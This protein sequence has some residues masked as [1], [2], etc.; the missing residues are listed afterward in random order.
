[1]VAEES[2][3]SI[4]E[5]D[6][7]S[8]NGGQDS[9]YGMESPMA[10]N[11]AMGQDFDLDLSEATMENGSV[12]AALAEESYGNVG[13]SEMGSDSL[14][15]ATGIFT[16][17]GPNDFELDLS[18]A[19]SENVMPSSM[20]LD[21]E[22]EEMEISDVEIGESEDT[23]NMALFDSGAE[24]E[25]EAEIDLSE[26]ALDSE[27]VEGMG[28]GSDSVDEVNV[29]VADGD[30]LD[31]D[32]NIDP[33]TEDSGDLNL[34][35]EEVSLDE[36]TDL[37]LSSDDD[38]MAEITSEE[39]TEGGIEFDLDMGEDTD[40]P[41][42]VDDEDPTVDLADDLDDG[43]SLDIEGLELEAPPEDEEPKE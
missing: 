39:D 2:G 13:E 11:G 1:M 40:E 7:S 9:D 35:T 23:D 31:L 25:G 26:E 3:F 36:E 33:D 18:E 17:I 5:G 32:L 20:S 21:A 42:L 12:G 8:F 16:D 10:G 24:D 43:S 28:F 19:V 38:V 29:E 15:Q 22:G 6:P 41:T 14:F 34:D 4:Y 27:E 30:D 37:D